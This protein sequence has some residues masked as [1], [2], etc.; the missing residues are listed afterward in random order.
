MI[1]QQSAQSDSQLARRQD[2][3]SMTVVRRVEQHSTQHIE[4]PTS[5]ADQQGTLVEETHLIEQIKLEVSVTASKKEAG[6]TITY[7]L[8]PDNL[9]EMIGKIKAFDKAFYTDAFPG[10][11][12]RNAGAS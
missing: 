11:K 9:D 10:G 5:S 8:T 2:V 7:M 1:E 6:Y 12:S 4:S 3:P